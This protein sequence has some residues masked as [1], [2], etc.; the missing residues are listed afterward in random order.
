MKIQSRASFVNHPPPR[1]HISLSKTLQENPCMAPV[2]EHRWSELLVED[3][4][5]VF[6]T[7]QIMTL[8]GPGVGQAQT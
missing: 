4:H 5:M 6:F 8:A 2:H 7:K 1:T 3:A